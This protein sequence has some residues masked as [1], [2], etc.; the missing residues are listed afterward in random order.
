MIKPNLDE[1][2]TNSLLIKPNGNQIKVKAWVQS[3]LILLNDVNVPIEVGDYLEQTRSNG[4]TDRYEIIAVTVYDRGPLKHIEAKYHVRVNTQTNPSFNINGNI[5]AERVY[6][7][8]TDNSTN[9]ISNEQKFNELKQAVTTLHN[10]KELIE[11][12]TKLETAKD[13]KTYSEH[14]GKFLTM[15]ADSITIVSPFI[16]WLTSLF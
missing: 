8:S 2:Y 6:I 14:L 12:I 3:E 13:K 9:T 5:S 11:I 4:I 15:A 7:N 10:A 1:Y 16:S